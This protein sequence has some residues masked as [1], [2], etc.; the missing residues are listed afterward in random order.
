M[1]EEYDSKP[2][3]LRA[4]K[5]PDHSVGALPRVIRSIQG[6]SMSKNLI[7]HN[8]PRPAGGGEHGKAKIR[9]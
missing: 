5:T 4:Q 8:H 9:L 2:A 1:I 7:L 6:F 3:E